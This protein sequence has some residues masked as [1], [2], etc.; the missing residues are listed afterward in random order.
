MQTSHTTPWS[1]KGYDK[2]HLPLKSNCQDTTYLTCNYEKEEA[3]HLTLQRMQTRMQV[4]RACPSANTLSEGR[5][6]DSDL[7]CAVAGTPQLRD[8][9]VTWR[10]VVTCRNKVPTLHVLEYACPEA[11][12]EQTISVATKHCNSCG[13][14]KHAQ[15]LNYI[16]CCF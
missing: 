5:V 6:A 4:R 11:V 14:F 7:R 2:Q 15:Q 3:S 10:V 12:H 13:A 16:S 8:C 9:Q 1:C